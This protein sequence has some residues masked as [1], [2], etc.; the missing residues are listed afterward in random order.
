MFR[1]IWLLLIIV[2]VIGS[3][4]PK[5]VIAQDTE[6]QAENPSKVLNQRVFLLTHPQLIAQLE[7][8]LTGMTR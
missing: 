2:C 5:D 7:N 1:P 4:F 6:T 3:G 8:E